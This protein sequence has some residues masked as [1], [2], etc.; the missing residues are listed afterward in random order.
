M[1]PLLVNV[2]SDADSRGTPVFRARN[3]ANR[4]LNDDGEISNL[5]FGGRRDGIISKNFLLVNGAN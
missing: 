3:S 2:D 1:P 4:Q 5:S